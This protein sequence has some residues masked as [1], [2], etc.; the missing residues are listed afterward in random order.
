MATALGAERDERGL[1]P[2]PDPPDPEPEGSFT[3]VAMAGLPMTPV[4]AGLAATDS[5]YATTLGTAA[6]ALVSRALAMAG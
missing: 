2:P 3:S 5:N 4:T 1:P 6:R